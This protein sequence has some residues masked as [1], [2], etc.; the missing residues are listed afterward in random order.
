MLLL[1]IA[2]CLN[3][4]CENK[5]VEWFTLDPDKIEMECEAKRTN[6]NS[7]VILI[8]DCH[9]PFYKAPEEIIEMTDYELPPQWFYST[10]D[11]AENINY[12]GEDINSQCLVFI[13]E[14]ENIQVCLP[15]RNVIVS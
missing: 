2:L 7:L 1:I 10:N 5:S 3:I 4:S 11:P 12:F 14:K 9:I 8:K 15:W 13:T 6:P